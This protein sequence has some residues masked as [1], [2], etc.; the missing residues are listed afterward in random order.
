VSFGKKKIDFKR[1]DY[2]NFASL[3]DKAI[4]E[5]SAT[6]V[7]VW[8]PG[9]EALISEIVKNMKRKAVIA[10]QTSIRQMASLMGRAKV[11]VCNDAGPLHIAVSQNCRTVS[12]FGPSDSSVYGPYPSNEHHAVVISGVECRPCYKRF[13]LP[14]CSHR[15][16]LKQVTVQDVFNAVRKSITS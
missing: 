15:R 7:L 14:E 12:I 11:C 6:V 1:W 2:E 10:P 5:L 16:C 13:K 3:A 4:D 8:G 9:E